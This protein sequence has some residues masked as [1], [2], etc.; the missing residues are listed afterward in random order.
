MQTLSVFHF[1]AQK[2]EFGLCV[3]Q[4]VPPAMKSIT[5]RGLMKVGKGAIPGA[6]SIKFIPRILLCSDRT[7]LFGFVWYYFVGYLTANSFDAG[8][9][10]LSWILVVVVV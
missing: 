1:S 6:K 9:Y 2:S 8:I 7:Y 3:V 10:E 5:E 4:P